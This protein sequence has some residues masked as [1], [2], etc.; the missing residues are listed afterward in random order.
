MWVASYSLKKSLDRDWLV[1]IRP[2]EKIRFKRTISSRIRLYTQQHFLDSFSFFTVQGVV[3]IT[4]WKDLP[5]FFLFACYSL[6]MYVKL[7]FL[8]C[9]VSNVFNTYSILYSISEKNIGQRS[10]ST[11]ITRGIRKRINLVC[12]FVD[13]IQVSIKTGNLKPIWLKMLG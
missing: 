6:D 11:K 10:T 8:F 9:V 4:R 12:I 7:V 5:R 2:I 3:H 1:L 13:C